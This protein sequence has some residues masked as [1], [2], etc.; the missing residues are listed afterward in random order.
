[1]DQ[2]KIWQQDMQMKKIKIYSDNHSKNFWKFMAI[3]Q[4]LTKW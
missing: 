3:L 4:T 2:E 1:M